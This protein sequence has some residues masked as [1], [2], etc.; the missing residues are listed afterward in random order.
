MES[1]VRFSSGSAIALTTY[2]CACS[3]S[4]S[5]FQLDASAQAPCTST[6]VGFTPSGAAAEVPG[7]ISDHAIAA[8]HTRAK[9]RAARRTF[10]KVMGMTFACKSVRVIAAGAQPLYRLAGRPGGPGF[11][12]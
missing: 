10:V 9:E 1:V 7:V 2:P 8:L 11:V 6:M 4:T 3:S 12:E 5:P